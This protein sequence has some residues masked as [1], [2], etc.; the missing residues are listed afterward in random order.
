MLAARLVP[1]LALV[2]LVLGVVAAVVLVRGVGGG[3][4][5][6]GGTPDRAAADPAGADRL[7]GPRR[8][9]AEWD[10]ARA[11][12]WADG[13]PDA[14]AALYTPRSPAGAT[15]VRAL[16][17]WLDRGLVVAG[18]QTQVLSFVVRLERPRRLVVDVTDRS[19]GGRAVDARD[20]GDEE[21]EA[22]PQDA[23]D[24]RRI[25]FVRRD[26]RWLVAEVVPAADR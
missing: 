13:D 5:E 8:V 1:K 15:D 6:L 17:R 20:E 22:L 4:G 18:L 23:P 19:V 16:R 2:A 10:A 26:G 9:L 14:L 25:T 12:A 3:D 24:D 11:R 21:G 7:D